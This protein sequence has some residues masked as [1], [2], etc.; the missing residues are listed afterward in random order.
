MWRANHAR[1][2]TKLRLNT[3]PHS[4]GRFRTIGPVSNM[5][6]FQKAFDLPD[7]SPMVRPAK[8]RANIW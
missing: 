3:D 5:P 8:D 7:N 1:Q 6:E 4:P 2:E